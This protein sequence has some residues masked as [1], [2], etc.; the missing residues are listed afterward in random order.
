M[1]EPNNKEDSLPKYVFVEIPSFKPP[2][3]VCVW[4]EKNST[5]SYE[6]I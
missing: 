6:N 1:T 4:N 2:D 5:A 3:G